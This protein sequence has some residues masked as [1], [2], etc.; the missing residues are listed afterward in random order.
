MKITVSQG[1]LQRTTWRFNIEYVQEVLLIIYKQSDDGYTV[2][3]LPKW[4]ALH[5]SL[6][7]S[8]SVV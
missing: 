1:R 5:Y 2:Q 6:A 8:K 7:E 3:K 4:K